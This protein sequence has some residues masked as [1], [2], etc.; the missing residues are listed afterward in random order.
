MRQLCDHWWVWAR[1]GWFKQQSRT[2]LLL[3]TDSSGTRV[4][5][6]CEP[7]QRCPAATPPAPCHAHLH[8]RACMQMVSL[9]HLAEI[10]EE[11]VTFQS[12]VD[13]TRML[14]TPE[15]SMGIQNRLGADIMMALGGWLRLHA[16]HPEQTS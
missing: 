2:V 6:S 14:L 8:T 11:G 15:E 4:C 3:P 12:P 1:K 13:G 10:T 16:G 5:I 9:L 7:L